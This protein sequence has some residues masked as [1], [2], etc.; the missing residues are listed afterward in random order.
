MTAPMLADRLQVLETEHVESVQAVRDAWVNGWEQ[1]AA[2]TGATNTDVETAAEEI[3]TATV[4]NDSTNDN[5]TVGL[6]TLTPRPLWEAALPNCDMSEPMA[7]WN[8]GGA[9]SND[10]GQLYLTSITS[11]QDQSYTT[12]Q[13]GI[14][15]D[16]QVPLYV[17]VYAVNPLTGLATLV[18]DCGD[19]RPYIR[20]LTTNAQPANTELVSV[21]LPSALTA[22][23]GDIFY[24]GFLNIEE[25]SSLLTA[26]GGYAP[27]EAAFVFPTFYRGAASGSG[28]S[29]LPSTVTDASTQAWRTP[30]AALGYNPNTARTK[31]IIYDGFNT[32]FTSHWVNRNAGWNLDGSGYPIDDNDNRGALMKST[33]IG[34]A[35]CSNTTQFTT[36]NQAVMIQ[37]GTSGPLSAGRGGCMILRL[38]PSSLLFPYAMIFGSSNSSPFDYYIRTHTSFNLGTNLASG[39]TR[40]SASG[41][42][43]SPLKFT[44]V[45]NVYTLWSGGVSIGS[46]VGWT[47]RLQWTDSGNIVPIG[48]SNRSWGYAATGSLTQPWIMGAEL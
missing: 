39:T 3:K 43:G 33:S 8:V 38:N 13:F 24:V 23:R 32:P 16:A 46:N 35:T 15:T 12:V 44:A 1:N 45:G 2:G 37:T 18:A 4:N 42:F 27:I 30:W 21:P 25:V 10:I 36:D 22:H 5:T 9:D 26:G 31:A 29:S 48:A 6:S 28:L 41:S 7:Y 19:V 14:N 34:S 17:G 11:T 20:G 40:A 47:Q